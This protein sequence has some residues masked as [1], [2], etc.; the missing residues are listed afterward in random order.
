ISFPGGFYT[1]QQPWNR[2]AYFWFD[3]LTVLISYFTLNLMFLNLE[4]FMTPMVQQKDKI[5]YHNFTKFD[6]MKE[7]FELFSYVQPANC[8]EWNCMIRLNEIETTLFYLITTVSFI[9]HVTLH[10][11][12]ICGRFAGYNEFLKTLQNYRET[13]PMQEIEDMYTQ[14]TSLSI[15]HIT[16][17]NTSITHEMFNM[18]SYDASN[19]SLNYEELTTNSDK[20]FQNDI[21]FKDNIENFTH[22][23]PSVNE[24]AT[25]SQ[26]LELLREKTHSTIDDD[27]DLF[28][29]QLTTGNQYQKEYTTNTSSQDS[30][31]AISEDDLP[32][33]SKEYLGGHYVEKVLIWSAAQRWEAKQRAH[34][35]WIHTIGTGFDILVHMVFVMWHVKVLNNL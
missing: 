12:Y 1:A 15:G 20:K 27:D 6:I 24:D 3:L 18:T 14:E 13:M 35:H 4:I 26:L 31:A 7:E 10:V 11:L 22:V 25:A 2:Y 34:W 29:T 21:Y 5:F 23:T 8:K 33:S 28:S 16:R 9:G 19:P 30:N 32:Q 17:S